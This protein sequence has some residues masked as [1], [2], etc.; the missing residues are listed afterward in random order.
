MKE[1]KLSNNILVSTNDLGVVTVL[2][3]REAKRNAFDDL[4]IDELISI[5][6]EIAKSD[7]RVMVLEAKGKT[8]SAGADLNWMKKTDSY[9]YEE[10]LEDAKNLALLLKTLHDMPMTTIAK[11]NG[12]AFGGAV[13]LICCCDIVVAS[14]KSKF[15]FSEVKIGL[16]PATISPYVIS[17]I[18]QRAAKRFFQT[19]ELIDSETAL[20][21]GLVSDVQT[22][23]KLNCKVNEMLMSLLDNS[24]Q[25]TRKAKQLVKDVADQPI[26][27][28]L[29]EDTSKWIADIRTTTEGQEGLAAFLEK[30]PAK[31]QEA[32]APS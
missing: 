2:L 17:V 9:S 13:G 5:F 28:A 29:I 10:N 12:N 26:T 11:V 1:K 25:A 4:M 24:P 18:G 3:N 16:I 20:R 31:W 27:I 8:F 23:H 14:Q 32:K 19:A 15:C 21:I 22:S 30:R 7:A 6:S